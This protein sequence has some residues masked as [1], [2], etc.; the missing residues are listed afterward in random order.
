MGTCS[1]SGASSLVASPTGGNNGFNHTGSGVPC[2]ECNYLYT[3]ASNFREHMSSK[4]FKKELQ[5]LIEAT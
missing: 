5:K 4:H 1:S 2:I 3:T